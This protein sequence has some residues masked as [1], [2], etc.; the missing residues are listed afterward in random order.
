MRPCDPGVKE[1]IPVSSLHLSSLL[2]WEKDE[3]RKNPAL[4]RSSQS[5]AGRYGLSECNSQRGG[6]SE[7]LPNDHH[8][9][10]LTVWLS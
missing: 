2:S 9:G 8:Q 4:G 3:I 5:L 7:Q 6:I 1:Q 10:V